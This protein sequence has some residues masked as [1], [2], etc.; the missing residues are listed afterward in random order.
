[1]ALTLAPVAVLAASLLVGAPTLA[2][3]RGIRWA[4][5]EPSAAAPWLLHNATGWANTSRAVSSATVGI[6]V[7]PVFA[8]NTTGHLTAAYPDKLLDGS[9]DAYAAAGHE[10]VLD[11]GPWVGSSGGFV[12]RSGGYAGPALQGL[13]CSSLT[14]EKEA[15]AKHCV[16][17]D[18]I[19]RAALAR[20]EAF[21]AEL[22]AVLSNSKATGFT[23]DWET[24]YGNNQTN[25][26]SLWGYVKHVAASRGGS[27]TFMPWISNGGG[28]N[29]GPSNYAYCWDYFPLLPFADALLNMGS[30]VT[31]N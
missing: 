8:I 2:R 18:Q 11:V 17:P 25:A 24:S 12:D 23:T 26:A 27:T 4:V 19:I 1:M 20:K 13:N 29:M 7:L 5:N 22:L 3:G 10:I 6:V 16:L 15:A 21:A 30:Y 28:V 9:L 31:L 14:S